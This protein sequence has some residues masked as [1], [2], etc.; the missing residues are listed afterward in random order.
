MRWWWW[1]REWRVVGDGGVVWGGVRW[2]AEIPCCVSLSCVDVCRFCPNSLENG[3]RAVGRFVA[4]R[5]IMRSGARA[6]SFF[7]KEPP[8]NFTCSLTVLARGSDDDWRFLR[9]IKSQNPSDV[10][11]CQ[12]PYLISKNQLLVRGLCFSSLIIHFGFE[13]YKDVENR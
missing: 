7:E 11:I 2:R 12:W 5:K 1:M 9:P 4:A 3:Q 13:M 8:L 6:L 10:R